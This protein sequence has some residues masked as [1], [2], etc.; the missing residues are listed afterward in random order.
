MP[1][2]VSTID[3][4]RTLPALRSIETAFSAS[5]LHPAVLGAL[6]DLG[7]AVHD[8]AEVNIVTRCA[9]MRTYSPAVVW[10]A[11]FNPNPAGIDRL[12]PSTFEKVSFD[13]V[14]AA[15]S[16]ALEGPFRTATSSMAA[17][18]LAELAGL[19]RT[20]TETAARKL[21]GPS[22]V[23]GLGIT[24]VPRR[25]PPDGVARRPTPPRAPR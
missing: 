9:A 10:S 13:A 5:V 22:L 2:T 15:Q 7:V 24:A 17:G 20:V 3:S 19:C 4:S 11:F 8:V 21:R 12:I 18:E 16:D 6:Q 14:L 1:L 25:G 23:R